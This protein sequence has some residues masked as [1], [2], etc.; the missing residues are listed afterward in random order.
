MGP[1]LTNQ[2][3]IQHELEA[4]SALLKLSSRKWGL[5]LSKAAPQEATGLC[6]REPP[7]ELLAEKGSAS[8][9]LG[10]AS[11]GQLAKIRLPRYCRAARSSDDPALLSPQHLYAMQELQWQ[12]S[13]HCSC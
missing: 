9:N 11:S 13:T 7:V 4:P 6:S 8:A 12:G 5:V 3:V 2:A 1:R 10:L